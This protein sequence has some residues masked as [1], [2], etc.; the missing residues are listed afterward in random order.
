MDNGRCVRMLSN[1]SFAE[2]WLP[3]MDSTLSCSLA[4]EHHMQIIIIHL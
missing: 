3:E 2:L 4:L 1:S